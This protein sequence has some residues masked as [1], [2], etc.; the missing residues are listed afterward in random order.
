MHIY[1][2]LRFPDFVVPVYLTIVI[3][4]KFQ[5]LLLEFFHA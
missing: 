5:I 2:I 1:A 3:Y 4:V